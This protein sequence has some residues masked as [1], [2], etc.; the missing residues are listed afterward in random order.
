CERCA[1]RFSPHPLGRASV[2]QYSIAVRRFGGEVWSQPCACRAVSI[3][4]GANGEMGQTRMQS[5]A[6]SGSNRIEHLAA[7]RR[8]R[9]EE[10]AAAAARER[11]WRHVSRFCGA[12]RLLVFAAV[13]A[14][15]LRA[16]Q[17]GGGSTLVVAAITAFATLVLVHGRVRD[18]ERRARWRRIACE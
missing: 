9:S 7:L 6:T 12:G 18:A 1:T 13:V 2:R 16:S 8:Q 4:Y 10:A 14:L 5:I 11:H 3:E 17:N 15:V